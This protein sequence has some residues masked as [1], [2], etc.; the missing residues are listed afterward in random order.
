MYMCVCL[1]VCLCT[2]VQELMEVR[3]GHRIPWS[4][5]STWLGAALWVLGTRFSAKADGASLFS[6]TTRVLT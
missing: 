3:G 1:S 6:D 5:S 2:T 4:W